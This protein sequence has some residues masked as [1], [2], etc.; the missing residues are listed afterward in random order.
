MTGLPSAPARI[1]HFNRVKRCLDIVVLVLA[2][3]LAIVAGSMTWLTVL[4]FL[5]RPVMFRQ[6][7]VG[8]D[9]RVFT[10]F[11][12][13]TMSDARD[14]SGALLDDRI[15][16]S[17]AGR[18]LR[19]LS[20]D[21]LPQL[22]NVAR[23]EM[24]IVGP[25][26]LLVRYLPFYSER[27]RTRHWVRPGITGY[28]QVAG[29][30]SVLWDRRLSLDVDYVERASLA[31]DLWIVAKTARQVLL[32]SGVSA[33]AGD[34]GEP[35]DTVRSY[36]RTHSV[37][38]RRL[39][40]PDLS[41]VEEWNLSGLDAGARTSDPRVAPRIRWG[42][43]EESRRSTERRYMTVF[44]TQS[45]LPVSVA[46]YDATNQDAV[47]NLTLLTPE[48]QSTQQRVESSLR[49]V[50]PWLCTDPLQRGCIVNV[51]PESETQRQAYERLGFRAGDAESTDVLS[52]DAA[53]W[54]HDG[55][56]SS[57]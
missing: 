8:L 51:R 32:S 54:R 15:R 5:G 24:S 57:G 30:N 6:P 18:A 49:V 42:E 39:E 35:L 7:R 34:S 3:P 1:R 45:L 36:P 2:S 56:T 28:A 19:L 14:Q 11:K 26:P 50:L 21:E 31:L 33:I 23:G 37:G 20:L 46:V 27:E 13:R 4:V 40:S 52:F 43:V 48:D 10:A 17:R 55:T 53:S 9:E 29:R 12:F 44:D 16:L 22:L 38:L 25:R 47:P 41:L